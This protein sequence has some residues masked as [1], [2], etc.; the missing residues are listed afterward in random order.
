MTPRFVQPFTHSYT[1][2]VSSEGVYVCLATNMKTLCALHE[3][4]E[5]GYC[6]ILNGFG[7]LADTPYFVCWSSLRQFANLHMAFMR[8]GK[9]PCCLLH[10]KRI[11]AF[12]TSIFFNRTVEIKDRL[13]FTPV[14]V[15]Q[16]FT[17]MT[18]ISLHKSL[19]N[20]VLKTEWSKRFLWAILIECPK[21]SLKELRN[22]TRSLSRNSLLL[23]KRTRITRTW[24]ITSNHSTVSFIL[25]R[26]SWTLSMKYQFLCLI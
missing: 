20:N 18:G 25:E 7:V 11:M 26:I 6:S 8:T 4:H 1:A 9:G 23:D 15:C 22:S 19:F 2:V 13:T 12:T 14:G 24:L 10:G 5:S 16:W 17:A 21:A 3:K